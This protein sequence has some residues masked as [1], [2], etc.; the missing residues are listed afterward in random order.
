MI[1]RDRKIKY[2]PLI[3]KKKKEKKKEKRKGM[4]LFY[5][6]VLRVILD[7]YTYSLL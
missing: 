2:I 6:V 1:G 4:L 3:F 5:V 7:N